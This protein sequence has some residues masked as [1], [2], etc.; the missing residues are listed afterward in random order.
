LKFWAVNFPKLANLKAEVPLN[1]ENSG[2]PSIS[3]PNDVKE[4]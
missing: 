2:H 4:I 1:G 3:P